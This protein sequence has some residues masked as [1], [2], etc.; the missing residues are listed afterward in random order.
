MRGTEKGCSLRVTHVDCADILTAVAEL[1]SNI[2]ARPDLLT[3]TWNWFIA[4]SVRSC[5]NAVTGLPPALSLSVTGLVKNTGGILTTELLLGGCLPL[6]PMGKARDPP[7][8]RAP[9]S[10][11]SQR[12]VRPLRRTLY[13]HVRK[14]LVADSAKLVRTHL[15]IYFLQI[16]N[17]SK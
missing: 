4:Y 3:T 5:K 15:L 7:R 14:V 10:S 2:H 12:K 6:L 16:Q 8:P 9:H 13:E 17:L 11:S 1:R